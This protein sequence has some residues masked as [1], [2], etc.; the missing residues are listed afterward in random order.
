MREKIRGVDVY[1]PGKLENRRD[2]VIDLANSLIGNEDDMVSKM[3]KVFENKRHD[4]VAVVARNR[5]RRFEV[6]GYEKARNLM[7][8]LDWKMR[9]TMDGELITRTEVYHPKANPAGYVVRKDSGV[10]IMAECRE[11]GR[12]DDSTAI[13]GFDWDGTDDNLI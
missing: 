3:V 7:R 5:G 8:Q 6:I 11:I 10:K 12:V 1:Y 13:L 9:V 4:L 2:E